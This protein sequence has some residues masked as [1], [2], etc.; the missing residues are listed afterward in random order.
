MGHMKGLKREREGKKSNIDEVVKEGGKK[1]RK[2]GRKGSEEV[3]R[4]QYRVNFKKK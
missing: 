2:E 4:G 3:R 1:G